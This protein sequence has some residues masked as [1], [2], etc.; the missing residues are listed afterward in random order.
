MARIGYI[1]RSY[2][3][4]SQTFIVNEILA[5]EQ[6]GVDL[7][8]FPIADP[9]EPIV[10]AQVGEVRAP[11][12]YLEAATRRPRAAIAAEHLRALL[13]APMGYLRALRYVLR[14]KDLDAGYTSA[15]RVECFAYAVY[16]ARRLRVKMVGR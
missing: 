12:D 6:I 4:L 1:I 2:P 3:R 10:Q 11:V 8:L 13:A 15:T 16:L 14:R 7:H 9:R 5:L